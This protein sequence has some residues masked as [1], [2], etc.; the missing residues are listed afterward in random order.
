MTGITLTAE[1]IRNAPAAVRQWIEQEVISS[2]GLA[3]RAPVTIPPQASH[4]VACSV[5][6]VAGVL[7]HIR[8]VL[9]AVNVLLELGRPGIS[10]GQP[11]VMTF[12]LMD[13]LHHTR[14][15]DV[16]EVF[17]CLEMINQALIEVKKDP[18]V[19]FCGFDNEGH[20]LIAPQ[21]QTSI[22]TLWQTMMERQQAAQQRAAAGRAA[23]AA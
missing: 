17:T 7:E 10:F 23:P 22:A 20:C 4:L 9:P 18:L 21:T 5:E 11:A 3:P 8:G 16:S 14:L 12:R 2:L 19:R 13:I 6:D 1:Q 15:H